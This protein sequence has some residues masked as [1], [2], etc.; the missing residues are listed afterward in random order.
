MRG[1]G[2]RKCYSGN[3][4]D[5]LCPLLLLLLLLILLLL[6]QPPGLVVNSKQPLTT[7]S[8]VL[9]NNNSDPA[10]DYQ[11]TTVVLAIAVA[12]LMQPHSNFLTTTTTPD[13]PRNMVIKVQKLSQP[14]KLTRPLITNHPLQ[15]HPIVNKIHRNRHNPML[16]LILSIISRIYPLEL[17]HQ[18]NITTQTLDTTRLLKYIYIPSVV[19]K[20][21]RTRGE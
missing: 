10:L 15:A 11:L 5:R 4:P 3:M 2:W 21:R 14:T 19:C 20:T 9:G 8:L 18:T 6:P 17:I 12:V 7:I 13:P 1:G 16:T